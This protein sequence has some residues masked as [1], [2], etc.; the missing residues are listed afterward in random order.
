MR[1][2]R[3][4]RW[5]SGMAIVAIVVTG[6][7][8]GSGDSAAPATA[9]ASQ[10]AGRR[11]RRG[12][13]GAQ[14]AAPA[15]AAP[16]TC[17]GAGDKGDVKMLINQWVGA[18]ANVAVA[19]C[20]LQQMGYTVKTSTLAEEVAWQGFDTG[21][22]DVI[23]EN[24]GHPDLEKTYITDKKLAADAGPNGVDRDHRL[25]RPRLDG[26]PVPGHHRLEQPQQVR[27]PVQD[28][29]SPATRASSSAATRPSS[30]TTR[31]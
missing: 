22:V 13:G 7:A 9:A 19:Q 12:L 16:A 1:E 23:L 21:E 3:I 28:A 6:C 8:K 11:Q 30:S 5:L 27:R 25:V 14:R 17:T 10:R 15:A 18:E 29:P 4:G 20:L 26:R 24:W 2:H 31:R